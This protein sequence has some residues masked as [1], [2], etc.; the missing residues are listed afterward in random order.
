MASAKPCFTRSVLAWDA[1]H[2]NRVSSLFE[3][4]GLQAVPT[5]AVVLASTG[6][7]RKT[8]VDFA[9]VL[10]SEQRLVLHRQL[11]V[12]A[13]L[14]ANSRVTAAYDKDVADL[15]V[16]LAGSQPSKIC[17]DHGK[18]FNDCLSSTRKLLPDMR[19]T[20]TNVPLP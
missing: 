2:S 17:S 11:P 9:K 16:P 4:A 3:G 12:T 6:I 13:E 15:H 7:I 8:G 20:E 5:M 18:C 14:L 19:A 1:I 10:H